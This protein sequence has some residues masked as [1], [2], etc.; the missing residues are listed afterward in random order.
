[1]RARRFPERED[2]TGRMGGFMAHLRLN[3]L[4][5]GIA[6]S[7]DALQ[8]LTLIDAT[9][10]REVRSALRAICASGVERHRR[11]DDLFDA[12]WYSDGRERQVGASIER[13][14]PAQT[15]NLLS[16]LSSSA[17]GGRPETPDAAEDGEAEGGGT[18]KL[19]ASRLDALRGT[20]M[21]HFSTPEEIAAAEAVALQ[22]ARALRDRRSRRLRRARAGSALDLR[23]MA[24]RSIAHGGEPLELLRRK[25]PDRPVNIVALCDVSGSMSLYARIFLAFLR[26]L[27][28]ADS[29]TDVFLFHTRLVRISDVLRDGNGTRALEKLTLMANG[30]GGGTQI[31]LNLK[32]FNDQYARQ[33]VNGR[34]VLLI[35]SDGYDTGAPEEIGKELQRL[36]RRGGRIVWLNPLKG[37]AGYEPVA[38]GMAAALPHL[39]L[40]AAANTLDALAALEPQLHRI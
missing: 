36:K 40:F 14:P 39:D 35:L 24:R 38:R 5:A 10:G 26:G 12:Y 21:R 19:V 11:F 7:A 8:A 37:W 23:R 4:P 16:S 29:R 3:G 33:G 20:D 31:G 9:D 18:G 6:E 1:M 32:R 22:L 28:S 13:R 25:R 2:M 17:K 34:T 15:S 30:F 27:M